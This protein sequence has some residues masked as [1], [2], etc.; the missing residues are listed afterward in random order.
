MSF[1]AFRSKLGF[2][3]FLKV[4]FEGFAGRL[5]EASRATKARRLQPE[6][7]VGASEAASVFR[8]P[9]G[10]TGARRQDGIGSDGGVKSRKLC[11]REFSK[12]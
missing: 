7:Y 8:A 2:G 3:A 4:C 5:K 1:S 6:S 9:A 11:W 12:L 10:S